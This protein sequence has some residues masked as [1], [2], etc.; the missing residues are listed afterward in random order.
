MVDGIE[1]MIE[2]GSVTAFLDHHPPSA[3]SGASV[4]EKK[5]HHSA[6]EDDGK[7][8]FL[9]SLINNHQSTGPI[10]ATGIHGLQCTSTSS[11]SPL[12]RLQL[13]FYPYYLLLSSYLVF[14]R[15]KVQ[16]MIG[17]YTRASQTWDATRP[18]A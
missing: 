10:A 13:R 7:R 16:Q 11:F 6:S 3:A 15:S 4:A 9:P 1:E 12:T 18:M 2:R 8:I 17:K 5:H 14:F